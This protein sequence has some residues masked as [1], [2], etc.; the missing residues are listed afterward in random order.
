MQICDFALSIINIIIIII[1]TNERTNG[2]F[3]AR[4]LFFV[5]IAS[6]QCINWF[7]FD[8][9]GFKRVFLSFLD[10]GF[11][12]YWRVWVY[13][14][15][16]VIFVCVIRLFEKGLK[17]EK[18]SYAFVRQYMYMYVVVIALTRSGFFFNLLFSLFFWVPSS[19]FV[20][21]FL[22]FAK[23]LVVSSFVFF[24]F[25]SR[26]RELRAVSSVS[27]V[28]VGWF[29]DFLVLF[30]LSIGTGDCMCVCVSGCMIYF[31]IVI[32]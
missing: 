13:V 29:H 1:S 19:C 18:K 5:F 23:H 27:V 31:F 28:L 2:D 7:K 10:W 22:F 14:C 20:I 9:K 24:L 15:M 21:R 6:H 32:V 3:H 16:H 11:F 26:V 25:R 30:F 4:T 12:L 8:S 17:R